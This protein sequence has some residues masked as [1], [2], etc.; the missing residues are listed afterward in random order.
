MS[1][2]LLSP[3]CIGYVIKVF[4]AIAE[5]FVQKKKNTNSILSSDSFLN[6][7]IHCTMRLSTTPFKLEDCWTQEPLKIAFKRLC[8]I[9][10]TNIEKEIE[11][12]NFDISI[13]SLFYPF[14]KYCSLHRNTDETCFKDIIETIVLVANKRN[15]LQEEV[16]EFFKST[17]NKMEKNMILFNKVIEK[18]EELLIFDLTNNFLSSQFFKLCI[19]LLEISIDK[20]LNMNIQYKASEAVKTMFKFSNQLIYKLPDYTEMIYDNLEVYTK[21]YILEIKEIVKALSS[22]CFSVRETVLI[23]LE[24]LNKEREKCLNKIDSSDRFLLSKFSKT[25]N[26][27]HH[28]QSK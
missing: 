8:S 25:N 9:I 20:K 27:T 12:N 24:S 16:I 19:D 21:N 4:E 1:N 7:L 11:S 3:L 18:S 14:L 5:T 17:S 22:H 2:L 10:R 15:Q 28:H 6:S 26:I 13:I 23:C